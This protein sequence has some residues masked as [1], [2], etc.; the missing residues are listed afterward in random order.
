MCDA[1]RKLVA[2]LDGEL[3]A[4]E[5]LA[6]ERHVESCEGCRR[7][8]AFLRNASNAFDTY[9]ETVL[10]ART[11]RKVSHGIPVL[12]AAA[13][14]AMVAL[15]LFYPRTHVVPSRSV[16]I[17]P[18]VASEPAPVV[19]PQVEPSPRKTVHRRRPVPAVPQPAVRW[20][21]AETAVDIAIPAE[22]I[23][24]PGAMPAGMKL[25]AELSIAPDGS[26]RQVRLRQ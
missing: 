22:A 11:Q 13:L 8:C 10:A 21:P 26:V 4:D 9:C 2:W 14:A 20:Q 24:A 1:Q 23:F 16:P 25:F 6:V 12:A 3:S 15:F 7:Q 5:A 19:A 17:H 18:V